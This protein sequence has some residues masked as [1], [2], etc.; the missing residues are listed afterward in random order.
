MS[1]MVAS[2][3]LPLE[4]AYK[5]VDLDTITLLLGMMIVV[6]SLRLSGFFA[7]ANAWVGA[8]RRPGRCRPGRCSNRESGRARAR[9]NF[10]QR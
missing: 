7:V 8:W 3:A 2:G 5:A 1:L 4:D 6:A 10:R 9:D